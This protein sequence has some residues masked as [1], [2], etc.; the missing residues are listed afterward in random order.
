MTW[1][2]IKQA[3]EAAGINEDEEIAS[4]QC[5]NNDGD[6]NFK[7]MKLGNRLKLSEGISSEKARK[8]A[9]GCAI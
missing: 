3:V 7:K 4:I 1:R 5:E 8:D 6:H 2:E 9:D